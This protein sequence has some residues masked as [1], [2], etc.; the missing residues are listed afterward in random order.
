M[1][2]FRGRRDQQGAAAVE[3]ALVAPLLLTLVFGIIAFGFMLSFRQGLSQA[4]AEAARAAAVAP[5]SADRVAIAQDTVEEVLGSACG[6]AYLT[7]DIG[8]GSSC[9]SCF[10]VSLDYAYAADPSKLEFPGLSVIM[11]DHLTYTAVSEVSQ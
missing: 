4:A 2:A 9:T 3:F 6:S 7:C 8:P 10:E 1:S 11:P 5:A